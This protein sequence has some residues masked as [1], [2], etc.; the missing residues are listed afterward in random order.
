MLMKLWKQYAAVYPLKGRANS[1][2]GLLFLKYWKKALP[3]RISSSKANEGRGL[4]EQNG[5]GGSVFRS[6]QGDRRAADIAPILPAVSKPQL[7]DKDGRRG[8]VNRK[9][10]A[11]AWEA[12]HV[13][14]HP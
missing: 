13:L 14:G 8:A 1:W 10:G 6:G 7:G 5:S 12:Y 4:F 2:L 11:L 9:V 3:C